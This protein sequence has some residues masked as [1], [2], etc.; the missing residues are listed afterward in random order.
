MS[1]CSYSRIM[2][3]DAIA[4]ERDARPAVGSES[5]HHVCPWWIG[6]LLASP[7][8]RLVEP[9]E[10]LLGP[11]AKPG[12]TIVEPGCGMGFFSL[13]MARLVGSAGRVVC[14]DLQ[15]KMLDGLARRARR[16]GVA[17]R[18]TTRLCSPSDLSLRDLSGC[19]DL[20]VAIHMVHEVPDRARLLRQFSDVLKPGG[21]CLVV[22]PLGHVS[23]D[24]FSTTLALAAEAGLRNTG[25][26]PTGRRLTAV[27]VKDE[28]PK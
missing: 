1:S 7:I 11:Y 15:Q 27:L 22:E 16:A 9:P 6:Y 28:R 2:T 12:M 17:D 23:A 21:T 18:I 3:Q 26:I 4:S 25:G 19:A 24:D 5:T 14:V 13:P 8:R 10:R 20:V